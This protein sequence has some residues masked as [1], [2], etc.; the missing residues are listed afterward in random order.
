MRDVFNALIGHGEQNA[1]NMRLAYNVERFGA[2]LVVNTR[3]N[4][5]RPLDYRK[6]SFDWDNET[7]KPTINE[8]DWKVISEEADRIFEKQ[9]KKD[10]W[11]KR[12]KKDFKKGISSAVA[13]GAKQPFP[14]NI[15][16]IAAGIGA[17]MSGIAQANTALSGAP[18][19]AEGGMVTGPTMA[20]IGDNAS[21]KEAVIPFEKMGRFLDM[22]G[23]GGNN[24][25]VTGQFKLR[26]EDLIAT[27]NKA[28][29]SK[30]RG[31]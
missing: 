3:G 4:L 20:L 17:V 23:G 7:L 22:A 11:E 12:G 21:G 31:T 5:K 6:I 10:S 30:R 29:R 16:A 13:A 15:A 2:L 9:H 24:V 25:N 26:G 19:L 8:D 28:D 14:L 27:I 1:F 18:A